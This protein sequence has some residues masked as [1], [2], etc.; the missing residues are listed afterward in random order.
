MIL[1][2]LFWRYSEFLYLDVGIVLWVTRVVGLIFL[3]TI[4]IF[5]ILILI[6][7]L[8]TIKLKIENLKIGNNIPNK[9]EI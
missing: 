3:E 2:F 8:S 5:S 4:I 1:V 9:R 6:L 7:L